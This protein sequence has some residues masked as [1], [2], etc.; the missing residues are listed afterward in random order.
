MGLIVVLLAV[1]VLAFSLYDQQGPLGTT[2]APDAFNGLNA[3]TTM[4][5]LA[6]GQPSRRPG[7]PGDDDVAISVASAFSRNRLSVSTDTFS[8]RTVDGTRTLETVTGTMP[9]LSD[10]SIVI[11]AHRDALGSPAT[12]E[13]SGTATLIELSRSLS[14]ETHHRSIVLVSTSGSIGAAGA[15][16]LARNLPGPVDAVIVLGD[17]AGSQVRYPIVVP[18]SRGQQVAPPMLRNT[19]A[20]ALAAQAQLPPG[21][22]SFAGQFAHLAFPLSI[23]EQAPFGLSGYPAVLLSLSGE[24]GPA[25]NEQVQLPQITALGRTVLQTV[26]ALD[27]GPSV[28]APTPYVLLSGKVIPGWAIRLFVLAMMVPV[29]GATLDG[30]A[31]ARRR[32][33]SISRWVVWVLAG[34]LP[35]VLALAIVLGSRLVGLIKAAPPGPVGSGVLPPH[36]AGIAIL[37][38]IGCV[39][40]LSFVVLRPFVI[41]LAGGEPHARRRISEPANS[42]AGASVLLVM[43]AVSLAIWI[44]NPFAAA[45]LVPAL[46]LWMW[47][48]DPDVRPRAAVVAILLVVGLAPPV[49]VIAYYAV[50]LGLSPLDVAWN[51]TL[52]LAG[53]YVG[54]LAAIEWS[55]VL[56]CV[57]SVIA[58]AMRQARADRPEHAPVTVRGPVTY[59]GPGSLG[60]TESAL[61]R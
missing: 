33:H 16:Q 27:G 56:G 46:H 49:L 18:W 30:L 8:A 47:V 17:L 44:Q 24:R 57:A 3:Y 43:C 36:S 32:G 59:A 5:N 22:T 28:P 7:S 1:V 29:L 37:V 38:A 34:A 14:G 19:V 54:A 51:G 58:I 2:L 45:L 26:S 39:L 23:G 13:L 41:R 21:G 50:T 20:A 4:N 25:A 35:F 10:G 61:R 52:L 11:V 40:V 31:R 9:G 48:V 15:A 42:G 60:G 53:G 12:A 55:L 6:A